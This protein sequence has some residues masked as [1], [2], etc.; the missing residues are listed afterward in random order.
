VLG[1]L[2]K[3]LHRVEVVPYDVLLKRAKALLDNVE[4]YLLGAEA[5]SVV[6]DERQPRPAMSIP[7][8]PSRMPFAVSTQTRFCW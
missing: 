1:E 6:E 3:S 4:K 7:F 2:N 5:D 8:S